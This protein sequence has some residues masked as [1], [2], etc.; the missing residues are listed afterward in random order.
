VCYSSFFL[1]GDERK[2]VLLTC[3]GGVN[4]SSEVLSCARVG[5]GSL[6]FGV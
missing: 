3:D 5:S 2:A 6:L 1:V 4:F